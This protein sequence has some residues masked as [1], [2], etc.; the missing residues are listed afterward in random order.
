MSLRD[1]FN[2][3]A[4]AVR[5]NW[6]HL[7][8]LTRLLGAKEAAVF[9]VQWVLKKRLIQTRVP[10]IATK[11]LVRRNEADIRVLWQ[12]FG[13]RECDV[14]LPE[15]PEFI[16]DGGAYVGYSAVF[17]ANKYPNARILAVE[18]EGENCR[19]LRENCRNY[20]TI[21]IVQGG[22]WSSNRYLKIENPD[23]KS[24]AFQLCEAP[25]A[26]PDVVEGI[27]IPELLRRSGAHR[28][29]LLKLDIE[30]AEKEIFAPGE[31]DWMDH[32]RAMV[33]ETHGKECEEAVFRATSGGNFAVTRQGE[34][35]VF[36]R[37]AGVTKP[38]DG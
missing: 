10:G 11:L 21:S 7:R 23:V 35:L 13:N 16:I 14:P 33:V 36:I 15:P 38:N 2:R 18:P 28:I 22:L 30:G 5:L 3:L 27:T 20:P 8:S 24:C 12:I 29:D 9:L 4:A 34:K 19:L 37:K 26:E 25:A 32:V 1:T 6:S 31:C 17:Y